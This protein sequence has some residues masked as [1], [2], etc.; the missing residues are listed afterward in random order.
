MEYAVRQMR[1]DE[2]PLLEDFLYEAIFVPPDYEGDVPRSIIFD[3]PLCYAAI[4]DFGIYE[5]DIAFVATADGEPVGCCWAR[6]TEEYGHIDDETPSLSISVLEDHRG[7]GIGTDLL[8][9]MI[10]ELQDRGLDRVSL[11]VQKENP[12]ARL[13]Q[14]LGFE[15]VGDGF[16]DTE[17]LMVREL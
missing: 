9:A 4:E 13:Y 16:D 7:N 11:S 10:E 1:E 3:D 15:I 14:R 12:A 5:N 2:H 6:T 17:W 8:E